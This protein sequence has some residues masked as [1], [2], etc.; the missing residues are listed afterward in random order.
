M[1]EVKLHE[2]LVALPPSDPLIGDVL[3]HQHALGVPHDVL[4]REH[5]FKTWKNAEAARD[6]RAHDLLRQRMPPAMIRASWRSTSLS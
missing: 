1:S 4:A 3:D 5:Y 6:Q 2:L